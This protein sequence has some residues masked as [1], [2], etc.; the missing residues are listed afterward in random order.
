MTSNR[1]AKLDHGRPGQPLAPRAWLRGPLIC[2][3][4]LLG[5]GGPA[6]WAQPAATDAAAELEEEHPAVAAWRAADPQ[7]PAELMGAIEDLFQLGADRLAIRYADRLAA[8]EMTDQ[9]RVQLHRAVGSARLIRLAT[10]ERLGDQP[11]AFARRVLDAVRK[12][13]RDGKRLQQL[14]RQA[15]EAGGRQRQHALNDLRLA[16]GDAVQPL[17]RLLI[18]PP[19]APAAPRVR[20][21]LVELG[22][23][24]VEP[25]LAVLQSQDQQ[26]Q[27]EILQALAQLGHPSSLDDLLCHAVMPS[28]SEAHRQAAREGVA[29]LADQV[30]D[31]GAVKRK[32]YTTV[33]EYLTGGRRVRSDLEGKGPW[34]SWDEGSGEVT[35]RDLPVGHVAAAR[36]D[37][38]ARQL[39]RVDPNDPRLARLAALA[40]LTWG[41]L[42]GGL[43]QPLPAEVAAAVKELAPADPLDFFNELLGLAL[44]RQQVPAA[45]GAAQL[46]GLAAAE[47]G[48]APELLNYSGPVPTPLARALAHRDRRLRFAALEAVVTAAPPTL[49]AG[50]SGV[51]SALQ[52]FLSWGPRPRAVVADP[53]PARAQMMAA[54]LKANGWEADRFTSGRNLLRAAQQRAD[55]GVALIAF[56]I[57]RPDSR[58]TLASLREDPRT[59]DLP[60]GLISELRHR[61]EAELLV[62]Q[63][64]PT[65]TFVV[66]HDE[67][68]MQ[69]R[70][71]QLT[72]AAGDRFV[73][74]PQRLKHAQRALQ[75][76]V[77]LAGQRPPLFDLA[78]C[79][80]ALEAA[81]AHPDLAAAATDALAAL[82]SPAAQQALV[83][84]ASSPAQPLAIRQQASRAFIAAIQ[85]HGI[86]LTIAQIR[87]LD[88]Q[89][90]QQAD[91]GAAIEALLWAMLDALQ[92]QKP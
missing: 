78:S 82:G 57:E 92:T 49:F 29:R 22:T 64:P 83:T 1:H 76:V 77:Q 10:D 63:F 27:V 31:T 81:L 60:V 28:A 85:Q 89:Y 56:T 30:P 23:P 71:D 80:P 4:L 46:L 72:A 5:L 59:A 24:A 53:R 3:T 66:P 51:P 54:Q 37:R 43:D 62:Q 34:W 90:Q 36:A 19:G 47:A 41:K 86:G 9:Q 20:A 8:L 69:L 40:R 11:R 13:R 32:V 48:G 67:S 7:E 12:F 15:V 21:A 50:A 68:T 39:S 61:Q 91:D 52:F 73:A 44:R 87:Q 26:L 75:L 65:V 84:T 55:Y 14:A 42:S 2:G 79:E 18:D 17:V 38:L 70:L 33:H 25:L 58:E 45:V 6:V 74:H 16:G 88:Q 35:R